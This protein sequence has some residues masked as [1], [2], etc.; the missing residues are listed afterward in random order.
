MF[1]LVPELCAAGTYKNSTMTQCK[2]CEGNKISSEGSD[3]CRQCPAYSGEQANE[4]NTQCGKLDN[5]FLPTKQVIKL[6]S[7]HQTFYK[8]A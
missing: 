7:N 4:A 8:K 1:S 5:I 2:K 6:L 3:S